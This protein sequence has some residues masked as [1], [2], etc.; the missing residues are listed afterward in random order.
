MLEQE[1]KE[2][3]VKRDVPFFWSKFSDGD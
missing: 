1:L 2:M 3:E